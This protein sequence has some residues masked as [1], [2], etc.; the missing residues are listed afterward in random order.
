MDLTGACSTISE[1]EPREGK[2]SIVTFWSSCIA[3]WFSWELRGSTAS[4][5]GTGVRVEGRLAKESELDFVDSLRQDEGWSWL[6]AGDGVA[7][8]LEKKPRMLFCFPADDDMAVPFL[9]VEGVLAGVCLWGSDLLTMAADATA[10]LWQNTTKRRGAT[11]CRAKST[12]INT[13]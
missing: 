13:L 12:F 10:Q 2:E 6:G 3:S 9:T 7:E 1:E 5:L 11:T 4:L 8:A